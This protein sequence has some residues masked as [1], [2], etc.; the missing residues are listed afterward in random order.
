MA[1]N[2]KQK[3]IIERYRD[4][5]E[6]LQQALV[7]ASNSK[8]IVAVGKKSGLQIDKI[9]ELADETGLV[10]LGI[11]PPGE[12]IRNL[13]RRLELDPE[14]AKAVAEEINQQIFQPVRESLK[15]VH[16]LGAQ[17]AEKPSAIQAGAALKAEP[18][19][20][21][22]TRSEITEKIIPKRDVISFP[23]PLLAKERGLGGEVSAQIPKPAEIETKVKAIFDEIERKKSRKYAPEI[24]PI[25]AKNIPAESQSDQKDSL[26]ADLEK[27][28]SEAKPQQN[29]YQ[30]NIDPYREPI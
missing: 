20:P 7:S 22:P 19:K 2:D 30:K 21:L 27:K 26:E 6:D 15:K 5:P 4:L 14:K 18:R 10:M 3:N 28:L 17:P 13:A 11:T 23:P 25:F 24:P 1:E 29:N 16:G 12:F 8:I 9:G